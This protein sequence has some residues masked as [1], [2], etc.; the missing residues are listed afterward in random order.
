MSDPVDILAR[1]IWGEARGTGAA[2]M[3]HVASVVMNRVANASWWGSDVVSVCQHP[4]QFSCWNQGD[5]NREKLLAV[6]TEDPWFLMAKGIAAAAISGSLTD[7]T[8]GADS[9]YALSLDTK[10]A[11]TRGA[12]HTYS[13]GWHSFWRT[14]AKAPAPDD[15]ADALN[16]IEAEKDA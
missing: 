6:T 12:T 9:Y 10:P 14:V 3:R 15:S 13:D 16:A 8:N 4:Y 11:W 2:G 1:T 7:A 5:P